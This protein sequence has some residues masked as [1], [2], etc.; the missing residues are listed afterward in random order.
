MDTPNVLSDNLYKFVALSGLLGVLATVVLA[1]QLQYRYQYMMFQR[2]ADLAVM[3]DNSSD[4]KDQVAESGSS[5]H[6]ARADHDPRSD[7]AR[8][9]VRS[10]TYRD[11]VVQL[12]TKIQKIGI[13]AR[14]VS[15]ALLI[16]AGWG[17]GRWY[18][19]QRLLDALL[20]AE[21][22]KLNPPGRD[23]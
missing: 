2:E 7:L 4:M 9:T 12:T 19:L 22:A 1:T 15:L 23:K 16:A 21:V 8:R 6:P 18:K 3:H 10:N 11:Q 17:F 13:I 20:A 14:V 5:V